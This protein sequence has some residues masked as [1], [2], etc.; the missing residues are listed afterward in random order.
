M[1]SNKKLAS[2]ILRQA[3]WK[4]KDRKR[5]IMQTLIKGKKEQII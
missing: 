5:C 1:L 4:L 3:G 2:T